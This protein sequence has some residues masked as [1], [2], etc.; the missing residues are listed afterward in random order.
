MWLCVL[1]KCSYGGDERGWGRGGILEHG[2]FN[3]RFIFFFSSVLTKHI[4]FSC[5]QMV[6]NLVF[7]AK[8]LQILSSEGS[9]IAEN[10]RD[11]HASNE[12]LTSKEGPLTLKDLLRKLNK[13]ATLEDSLATRQTQKVRF[14]KF[15]VLLETFSYGFF[16]SSANR[17]LQLE[18]S[19]LP[20]EV[21]TFLSI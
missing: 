19:R 14:F 3:R 6:K 18:V 13:E 4:P 20:S 17:K 8:T 12:N 1:F 9:P 5:S 2:G 15:V 16:L 21:R 7:L 11:R 10:N